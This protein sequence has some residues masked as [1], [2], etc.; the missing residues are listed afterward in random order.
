[1]YRPPHLACNESPSAGLDK[2]YSKL[3]REF[4]PGIICAQ[5]FKMLWKEIDLWQPWSLSGSSTSLLENLLRRTDSLQLLHFWGLSTHAEICFPLLLPTLPEQGR[6]TGAGHL[7]LTWESSDRWPLFGALLSV[8]WDISQLNGGL[9]PFSILPFLSSHKP[10]YTPK[11]ALSS[12]IRS[13]PPLFLFPDTSTV[14]WVC[15]WPCLGTCFFEDP[16]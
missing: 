16:S 12:C 9:R 2:C 13:L 11:K 7:C 6:A 1:M 14:N 8:W 4:E 15:V 3:L 5:R 10:P